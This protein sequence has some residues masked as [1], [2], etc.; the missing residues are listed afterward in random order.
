MSTHRRHAGQSVLWPRGSLMGI[1]G[2]CGALRGHCGA[3]RLGY[4]NRVPAVRVKH[5]PG[6]ALTAAACSARAGL[7]T[8]SKQIMTEAGGHGRADKGPKYCYTPGT[9]RAGNAGS[10]Q[11]LR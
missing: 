11:A 7:K 4:P 9:C 6:D 1:A 10:A 5:G 8:A 3:L 2:H